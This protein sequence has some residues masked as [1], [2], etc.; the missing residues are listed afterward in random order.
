MA[1]DDRS[2]G[3]RN[4][5]EHLS[6]PSEIEYPQRAAHNDRRLRNPGLTIGNAHLDWLHIAVRS[7]SHPSAATD[8][9]DGGWL[10]TPVTG[11][12]GRF[13]IMV[14]DAQLRSDELQEFM[15]LLPV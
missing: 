12:I 4:P 8:F 10:R 11:S 6:T 1:L 2:R 9:Q 15:D 3:P 13:R 5:L 14:A 7:R